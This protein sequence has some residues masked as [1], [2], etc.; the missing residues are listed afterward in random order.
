MACRLAA[1]KTA[2]GAFLLFVIGAA[3]VGMPV[4]VRM[5]VAFSVMVIAAAVLA[6]FV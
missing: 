2:A 6:V 1:E 3:V 4:S 5:A